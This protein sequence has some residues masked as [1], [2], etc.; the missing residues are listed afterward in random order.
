MIYTCAG[1]SDIG[2]RR[3]NED[4][5]NIL[6]DSDTLIA[7][8]ADG[9]GGR[10]NG[11]LASRIVVEAIPKALEGRDFEDD[12]LGYAILEA[13]DALRQAKN[14]GCTTVAAL[15][16][17]GDCAL[18]AHVGDSRIYQFRGDNIVYQSLDHSVVQVAITLGELPREACREHQDRNKIYQA[19]GDGGADP[20][21]DLRQ[22]EVRPGDRFLLCSDGFWEPVT[23]EA[24]LETLRLSDCPEAWLEAMTALVRGAADPRQDNNTAVAIFAEA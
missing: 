24:M 11:D 6:Q 14:T 18:A 16:I 10:A 2:R 19:L 13:N 5:L 7:V 15:W 12:E 23:E 17:R 1:C 9:V 8:V 22:L 20:K 3:A 21:V 4:A